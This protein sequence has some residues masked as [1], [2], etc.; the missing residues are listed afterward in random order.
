M[1]MV[2]DTKFLRSVLLGAASMLI[3][4]SAFF[5]VGGTIENDALPM[6]P[7]RYDELDELP[8]TVFTSVD[9]RDPAEGKWNQPPPSAV[10]SPT[11]T[12]TKKQTLGSRNV[13]NV[14]KSNQQ[15]R[16][17][18]KSRVPAATPKKSKKKK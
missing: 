14:K 11:N 10:T 3:A 9:G 4:V 12:L 6:A 1:G 13:A 18:T 15:N 7:K 17:S 16:A 8:K 5:A 2:G